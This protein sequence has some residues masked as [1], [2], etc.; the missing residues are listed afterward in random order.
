MTETIE[1]VSIRKEIQLLES[2]ACSNVHGFVNFGLRQSS[3]AI[4]A[5]GLRSLK[6]QLNEKKEFAI[7]VFASIRS[8]L[9]PSV[10]IANVSRM[11][12]IMF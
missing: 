3:A 6:I 1:P 12:A 8:L 2:K 9:K 5:A 11:I 7:R 4:G 10:K